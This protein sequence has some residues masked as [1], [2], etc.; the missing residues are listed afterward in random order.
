MRVE[1]VQ[2][3]TAQ[4]ACKEGS[5][6]CEEDYTNTKTYKQA[7]TQGKKKISLITFAVFG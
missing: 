3:V 7:Q 1:G 4:D 6:T 5:E 2:A